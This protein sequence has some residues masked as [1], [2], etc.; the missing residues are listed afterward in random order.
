MCIC[1]VC[2]HLGLCVV[3]ACMCVYVHGY[4]E[5]CIAK[6]WVCVCMKCVHMNTVCAREH[7]GIVCAREHIDVCMYKMCT[8]TCV[9]VQG[10]CK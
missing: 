2:V 3:C 10:V 1:M 6:M 5:V 8:W 4:V 7:I 9:H